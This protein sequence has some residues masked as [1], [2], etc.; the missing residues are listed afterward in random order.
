LKI[1][2]SIKAF[3]RVYR[4]VRD[5]DITEKMGCWGY[6]D[7]TKDI[8]VLKKRDCEFTPGHEKQVFLHELFHVVD[9]N[10]QVG[11]SEEQVQTLAVGL[12]TIIEDNGLDFTN[13][14]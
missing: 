5:N 3:G 11:L 13:G 8:L 10:F 7:A 1:P 14:K 9:T 6:L 2:S 12:T 4:I